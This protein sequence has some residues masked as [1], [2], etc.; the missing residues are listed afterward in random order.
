MRCLSLVVLGVAA[1]ATC[2]FTVV[3]PDHPLLQQDEPDDD[4]DYD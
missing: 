1:E 4:S 3:P 2:R